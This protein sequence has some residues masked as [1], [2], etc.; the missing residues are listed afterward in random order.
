MQNEELSSTLLRAIVS[1]VSSQRE[2]AYRNT[3]RFLASQRD[4][5]PEPQAVP[6]LAADTQQHADDP[7]TQN[8]AQQALLVLPA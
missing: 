1:V 4:G 7:V 8:A 6:D 5:D 2:A 3:Q